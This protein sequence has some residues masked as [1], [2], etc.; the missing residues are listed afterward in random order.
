MNTAARICMELRFTNGGIIR[1]SLD[2][3]EALPKVSRDLF[4]I[5]PR[6]EQI[7]TVGF[8]KHGR[9]LWADIVKRI[10]VLG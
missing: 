5:F 8:A 4:E 6:L 1:R 9:P 7:I 3:E 10:D 2:E